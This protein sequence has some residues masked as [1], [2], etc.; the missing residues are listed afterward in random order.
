MNEE[1]LMYILLEDSPNPPTIKRDKSR[2]DNSIEVQLEMLDKLL[3][4]EVKKKEIKKTMSE[5]V[6]VFIILIVFL[7]LYLVFNYFMYYF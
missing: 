4:I 2:I 3:G 6:K 1:L 5:N 7:I